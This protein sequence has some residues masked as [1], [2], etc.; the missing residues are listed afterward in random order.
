[1]IRVSRRVDDDEQRDQAGN[2]TGPMSLQET[3]SHDDKRLAK[4]G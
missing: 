2:E 1:M 4:E 3:M